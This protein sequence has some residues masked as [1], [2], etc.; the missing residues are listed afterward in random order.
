M[1][2]LST[3]SES[4]PPRHHAYGIS[5][6]SLSLEQLVH[7]L[8]KD[9][10]SYCYQ[11]EFDTFS[12]ADARE[13]KTLQAER[14]EG[15][16]VF[17]VKYAVMLPEAQNAL[18][19]VLEEPRPNTYFFFVNS[20]IEQLLPTLQSRLELVS[21]VH[22]GG[23]QETVLDAKTFIST[24]LDKRFDMVAE[25]VKGAKDEELTKQS[26]MEFF[27]QLEQ[28]VHTTPL[29]KEKASSLETLTLARSLLAKNGASIK[30]ILDMVAVKV[31]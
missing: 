13:L 25:L 15:A 28:L 30:M 6:R 24:S 1:E 20:A 21:D 23:E 18:L 12:I 9:Q 27:D 10:L 26:V 3:L 7:M 8:P 19:K 11:K 5:S 29:T 14:S 17:V 22:T 4:W 16:K 31:S 2:Y